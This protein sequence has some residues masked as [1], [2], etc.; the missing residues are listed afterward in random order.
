M[1]IARWLITL[2]IFPNYWV[3]LFIG[4]VLEIYASS[5]FL[6]WFFKRRKWFFLL[7]PLSIIL[8][9]GTA[10]GLGFLRAYDPDSIVVRMSCTFTLYAVFLGGMFMLFA[11]R[12][13]PTLL[14]WVSVIAIR[15]IADGA[16]TMLVLAV[17]Q[18]R[19]SDGL[20]SG[21]HWAWNALLNDLIHLAVQ[22]PL[23]WFFARRSSTEENKE[24]VPHSIIIFIVLILTTVVTKTMLVAHSQESI[25]LYATGVVLTTALA[26]LALL[27][28]TEVL[29]GSSKAN[30]IAVME[31]VLASEQKQFEESKQSIQLINAKV[32][33]IKHRIEEFGDKVAA[34]T[35]EKLK[36]SV[37]IY[38]R[39][40][41]TG[42]QV[43]D[44]IL[45]AK[46][47]ECDSLGIRLTAIGNGK[48]LH[49]I[50]SSKRYYLFSN[51]ID[52]AIEAVKDV[53][54]PSKRLIGLCLSEE[55]SAIRI[56]SYNYFAGTRKIVNGTLPTSKAQKNGHGLGLKS[57]SYFVNEYRGK[58]EIRIKDDMFFLDISIPKKETR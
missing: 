30:E 4:N 23:G 18:D 16:H 9:M 50:P 22:L 1:L 32:H 37:S 13:M 28:R 14:A 21:A 35:L 39:Q 31:A 11:E 20:I 25:A 52:N 24:Y 34:D 56:E 8:T 15:E 46:S 45:Y 7:L 17:T 2:G 47:L 36:S 57:I 54:D 58:I 5:I 12:P 53:P 40:F 48:D 26:A 44:T 29:I 51:I 49:Y 27:V 33:D 43:L 38:D 41:H 10:I 6:F 3:P 42:S 19:M 55:P